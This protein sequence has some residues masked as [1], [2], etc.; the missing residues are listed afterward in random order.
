MTEAAR[1][2][3]TGSSAAQSVQSG[4][5]WAGQARAH[6]TGGEHEVGQL[7]SHLDLAGYDCSGHFMV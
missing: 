2:R 3:R 5:G 1:G 6:V 4:S 7:L